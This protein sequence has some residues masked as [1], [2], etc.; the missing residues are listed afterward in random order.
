MGFSGGSAVKESAYSVQDLD[1]IPEF[2]KIPF[3]REPESPIFWPGEFHNC[4]VHE[5]L[6]SGIQLS[7]FHFHYVMLCYVILY[8]IILYYIILWT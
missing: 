3:R 1:S 4:M 5:V 2:G 6:K 8:Y 7:D